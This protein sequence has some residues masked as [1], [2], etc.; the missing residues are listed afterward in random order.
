MVIALLV[1]RKGGGLWAPTNARAGMAQYFPDPAQASAADPRW[2]EGINRTAMHQTRQAIL[3]EDPMQFQEGASTTAFPVLVLFGEKDIYG[4]EAQLVDARV[5]GAVV[6]GWNWNAVFWMNVPLGVL[7]LVLGRLHLP[8]SRGE[9][10][11]LDLPGGV[12]IGASLLTIVVGISSG[13][14]AGWGSVRVLLLVVF[15]RREQRVAAPMIETQVL[16][17]EIGAF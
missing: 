15:L 7:L 14:T 4:S 5:G 8:Q 12:L 11:A 16:A 10:R 13:N 6:S 3:H 2:L 17:I 9:Q 1:A